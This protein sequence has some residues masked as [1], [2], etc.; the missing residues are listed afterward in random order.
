MALHVSLIDILGLEESRA[1]VLEEA[2]LK[3]IW[4]LDILSGVSEGTV[5]VWDVDTGELDLEQLIGYSDRVTSVAFSPDGKC[6]VSGSKDKTIRV[7]DAE[8]GALIS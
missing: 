2:L 8:T 6:I 7:W 1:T 4:L 3:I 5:R